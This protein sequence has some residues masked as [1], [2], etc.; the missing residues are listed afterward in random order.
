[1]L[2]ELIEF[3]IRVKNVEHA[4]TTAAARH[5]GD[6]S[7]PRAGAIVANVESFEGEDLRS[8]IARQEILGEPPTVLH[9]VPGGALDR[10]GVRD[11]DLVLALNGRAIEGGGQFA[12]SVLELSDPNARLEFSRNGERS[13]AMVSFDRSCPIY[14]DLVDSPLI[15]PWQVEKF[16]IDVPHGL[17]Q[18]EDSDDVLSVAL[19]HQL[20]H[21]LFD[22]RGESESESEDRADRLGL[23]IASEAGF[24]VRVAPDYWERVAREYF[25]LILPAEEVS[26]WQDRKSRARRFDQWPHRDIARRMALIRAASLVRGSPGSGVSAGPD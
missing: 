11:G 16:L 8:T 13:S 9:V 20:A 23:M 21:A 2:D 4:L 22:R 7:R 24:D 6:L 12:Q 25:W 17:L 3:R 18:I 15:V 1:M 5:C 10:S 26:V 14:F 19:G